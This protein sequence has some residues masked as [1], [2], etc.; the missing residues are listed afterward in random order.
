MLTV[1]KLIIAVVKIMYTAINIGLFKSGSIK[2]NENV[3]IVNIIK[4]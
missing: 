2:S 3:G 1:I 4:L